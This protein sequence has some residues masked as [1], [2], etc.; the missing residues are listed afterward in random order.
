M[1]YEDLTTYAETDPNSKIVV[2]TRRNTWTN[3]TADES[4]HV[5][6]PHNNNGDFDIAWQSYADS[7]SDGDNVPVCFCLEGAESGDDV[8]VWVYWGETGGGKC[9]VG[10]ELLYLGDFS[11]DEDN[12]NTT[13]SLD[14]LYYLR[15]KRDDDG[16]ASSAGQYTL[17]VYANESDRATESSALVSLSIDSPAIKFD[18]DTV[19]S[20]WTYTFGETEEHD[21]YTEY[22]DLDYANSIKNQVVTIV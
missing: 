21:G 18:F 10:L 17:G 20:V 2:A 16:G 22:L 5:T 13:L 14:T 8:F 12:D 6:K 4:A 11:G 1:A 19:H 3:L 9:Y 7:A 15:L